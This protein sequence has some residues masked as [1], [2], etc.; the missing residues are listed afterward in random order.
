M[1]IPCIEKHTNIGIAPCKECK[2]GEF[3]SDDFPCD[4]C[5]H[6][7]I[8]SCLFEPKKKLSDNSSITHSKR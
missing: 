5:R 1:T 7:A 2:Y 8:K 3:S 6:G 4:E